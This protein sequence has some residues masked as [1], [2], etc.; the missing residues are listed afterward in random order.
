MKTFLWRTEGRVL[1][2]ILGGVG[3]VLRS[4]GKSNFY[5]DISQSLS[6]MA[7]YLLTIRTVVIV[8]VLVIMRFLIGP[9]RSYTKFSNFAKMTKLYLVVCCQLPSHRDEKTCF[10]GADCLDLVFDDSCRSKG[11]VKTLWSSQK[12]I[13]KLKTYLSAHRSMWMLFEKSLFRID[14]RVFCLLLKYYL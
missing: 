11:W 8:A 9:G 5:T 10:Y 3:G 4:F 14:W 6:T 12:C 2:G 7:V 1:P 13:L